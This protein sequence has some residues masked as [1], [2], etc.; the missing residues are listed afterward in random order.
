[1]TGTPEELTDLTGYQ[2]VIPSN[3]SETAVELVAYEL[4]EYLATKGYNLS[5]V[6]DSVSASVKEILIGDTNRNTAVMPS[7]LAYA[8][9]R[10]SNSKIQIAASSSYGYEAALSYIQAKGGIPQ[11]T[12]KTGNAELLSMK[13]A[14]DSIRVMYYNNYLYQQ[15][16]RAD[17]APEALTNELQADIFEAYA[18]D[19]IGFQE[20]RNLTVRADMKAKLEALGYTYVDVEDEVVASGDYLSINDTPI[21]YNGSKLTLLA[22]GY[23]LY[24]RKM[25]TNF[26]VDANGTLNINNNDS[27]SLTWAVFQ[28]KETGKQFAVL[29][30]H[31]I[32][33]YSESLGNYAGAAN[34]ARVIDA[35][36]VLQVVNQIKALKNGA[37]KNIPMVFGGD[38][39]TKLGTDPI[40]TLTTGGFALARDMAAA[41]DAIY[42]TYGGKGYSTYDTE[43]KVFSN[44]RDVA[45]TDTGIDHILFENEEK[46]TVEK[47]LTLTNKIAR[48]PSDHPLKLVDFVID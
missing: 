41:D 22:S 14:D 44:I 1:M 11:K 3:A 45:T 47:Y 38:L 27:K 43:K 37:Y 12:S 24:S 4:K 2:I 19:V 39:N 29:S 36:E 6:K 7:D 20:F 42:D 17:G 31:F 34:A 21:F 25:N 18:P 10:D 35:K 28:V 26:Q 15:A 9:Y 32:H 46:V 13:K 5:V 8:I 40:N 33:D 23:H 48:I 16:G 30:T